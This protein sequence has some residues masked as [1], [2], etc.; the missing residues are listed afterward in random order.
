MA[1]PDEIGTL[2]QTLA[3]LLVTLRK[4]AGL[5]QGQLA[6]RIGYKRTHLS[7][8]ENCHRV[9]SAVFWDACDTALNADGRLRAAYSQIAAARAERERRHTERVRAEHQAKAEAWEARAPADDVAGAVELARPPRDAEAHP[10]EIMATTPPRRP[11]RSTADMVAHAQRPTRRLLEQDID[12]I[13]ERYRSLYHALPSDE[14]L[15]AITGHLHLTDRLL[16]RA[17]DSTRRSLASTVAETAGF[18]AWLHADLG[19]LR[20]MLRLYRMADAAAAV[21]GERALAAYVRGFFALGLVERGEPLRAHDQL[22]T[23]RTQAG[24]GSPLLSSWLAA[25]TA[26]VAAQLGRK[27]DAVQALGQAEH[28]LQ[29]ADAASTPAWMYQFDAARLSAVA[30]TC[31]LRLGHLKHAIGSLQEALDGLPVGCGRRRADVTTELARA[32]LVD[33]QAD[34]AAR[35]ASIAADAFGDWRSSA[36]FARIGR[37]STEL[38]D[39]GHAV[40]ANSLR[41]QV[42]A[43][44]PA[45]P[46]DS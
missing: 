30:G 14:L 13:T 40:S 4:P 15:P 35:L 9:A 8:V 38:A 45:V 23:A 19:D 10:G 5:S 36:G 28:A 43:L 22:D 29:R 31:Y 1:E 21:S 27:T 2:Q 3:D 25:I 16:S 34:E 7:N 32:Y 44:A 33:G 24:D 17:D 42:L 18:A 39:A 26:V 46:L 20:Q 6:G 12:P 11:P 37:I 41:D